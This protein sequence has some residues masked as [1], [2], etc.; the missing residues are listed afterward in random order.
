MADLI[1]LDKNPLNNIRN[2]TAIKYVMKNG[3]LYDGETLDKR[4]PIKAPITKAWWQLEA[5]N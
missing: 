4:Y 2:S 5:N 3:V 1:V